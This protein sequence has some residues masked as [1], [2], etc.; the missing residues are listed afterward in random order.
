[1]PARE[2]HNGYADVL[3]ASSV[4]VTIECLRILSVADTLILRLEERRQ[5]G[6]GPKQTLA[7]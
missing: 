7:G 4:P 3:Y 6:I 5:Q 2:P 1:M